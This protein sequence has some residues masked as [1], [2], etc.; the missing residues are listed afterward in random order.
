M[1]NTPNPLFRSHDERIRDKQS[2]DQLKVSIRTSHSAASS[3]ALL[4][5]L[6]GKVHLSNLI[7]IA[8][9]DMFTPEERKAAMDVIRDSVFVTNHLSGRK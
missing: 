8:G 4:N 6:V 2:D 1:F 5:Q 7:A 3:E 9:N